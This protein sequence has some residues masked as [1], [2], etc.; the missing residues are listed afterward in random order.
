M[1]W[2]PWANIEESGQ[3]H[4]LVYADLTWRDFEPQKGEYDFKH[5]EEEN[6]FSR[7]RE[8]GKRIVFRFILDKPGKSAH[9]DISDWLFEEINGD[10]DFYNNAYGSGFSSNYSNLILTERHRDAIHALG[11]RY[12]NNEFIAYVELGS[13]GHWGE[14]HVDLAAG[15]RPLSTENVRDIYVFHYKE[16]FPNTHLLTRCP[17]AIVAELQLGLYN[18]MTAD[19]SAITS[20]LDWIENGGEYSQTNEENGLTPMPDGWHT[21]PIG[22]EQSPE[23]TIEDIYSANL[24]ETI[25]LLKDSHTTYI[26]AESPV[27]LEDAALYQKQIDT[28]LSTIGYRLFLNAVERQSVVRF[29]MSLVGTI[30]FGN[31][32]IVPIYYNWLSVLFVFDVEHSILRTYPL[33]VDLRRILP[34]D[35][36]K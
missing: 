10:G 26:G 27:D 2:A 12:G 1:G 16:A 3:P 31:D 33:D 13:L 4:T 36:K 14:W 23:M 6:Q 25:R 28:V 29:C 18:D 34:G 7:W 19:Y 35:N 21:A 11:E 22:G 30:S 5:F 32:G 15:I 8:E 20:W 17:F 9:I 24:E